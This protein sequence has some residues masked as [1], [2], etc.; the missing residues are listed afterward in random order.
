MGK[1]KGDVVVLIILIILLVSINY[2][3]LDSLVIKEFSGREKVDVIRVIDGDTFEIVYNGN[4]TSVRLLGIN[5]PEKGE[6]YSAEAK[7]FLESKVLNKT[8]ELEFGKEKYDLY[9]RLLAYVYINRENVN[10]EVIKKGFANF[11]FPSGKDGHYEYFKNAWEECLNEN[12]NFCEKSKDACAECVKIK[13]WDVK[14][15]FVIF[16]N[17]CNFNCDITSW[18]VK[19]EGRKKFVFGSLILKGSQEV[20]LTAKDFNKNYVWTSTGDSLFLRDKEGGL[21]LWENY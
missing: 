14:K 15:D 6:K 7:Q 20:K 1:K 9:K 17:S 13:E 4:K 19:D 5:T 10:E 8:V 2:S 16:E 18:S 11:Y 3:W 12:I 21:V